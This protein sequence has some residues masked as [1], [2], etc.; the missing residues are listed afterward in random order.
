MNWPE[1]DEPYIDEFG[2]VDSR[3]HRAA[4][5][6]WP[7]AERLALS[8]LGDEQTGVRLLIKASATVS[9]RLGELDGGIESI[10]AFLWTTYRRL[11]L[12]ELKKLNGRKIIEWE[13]EAAVS[14]NPSQNVAGIEAGILIEELYLRMDEW[15]RKVFELRT[16]GYGFEMMESELGT[17]ANVI[18]A[19]FSREIA[20]LRSEIE[21]DS[22]AAAERV[23]GLKQN[24]V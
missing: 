23:A 17:K 12:A 11:V 9:R 13:I 21:A 18:R 24:D 22:L 2:P 20:R 7:N 4:R 6:L 1:L 5:Q 15:T 8:K 19:K 10:S 14:A 16:L 3:V